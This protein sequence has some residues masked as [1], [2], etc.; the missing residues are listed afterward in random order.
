MQLNRLLAVFH[1]I[2]GWGILAYIVFHVV[3]IHQI[4]FG[5]GAWAGA[6]ELDQNIL[7]RV[8]LV[9]VDV[10]LLFHALNG[11]RI[12]MVEWG[13]LLPAKVR[14]PELTSKPW[15]HNKRHRAYILFMGVIGT[16]M[17]VFFVIQYL[18]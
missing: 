17:T 15:H 1:R 14:P 16:L 12:I 6:L 4:S 3:Y 18:L 10:A 2:T 7:V 8:V 9:L 11:V 5:A 13:I